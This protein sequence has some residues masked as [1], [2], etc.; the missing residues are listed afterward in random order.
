MKDIIKWT[1]IH[2]SS[3][4]SKGL[5]FPIYDP[6]LLLKCSFYNKVKTTQTW[7][8]RLKEKRFAEG[9]FSP[10]SSHIDEVTGM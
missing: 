4:A 2:F 1:I 7:V 10:L 5:K 3:I 8:K 9:I 6:I